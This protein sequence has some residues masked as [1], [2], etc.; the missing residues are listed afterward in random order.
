MALFIRQDDNRTELQQRLAT[1]LQ[2]KARKR[3]QED[4][5]RPDGVSDS[6]YI[7]GTVGT[8]KY[9]WIWVIVLAA[10][11]VGIFVLIVTPR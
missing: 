11:V 6:A 4:N 7:K 8:T 3:A 1:E 2:E 10:V 5:K 9:A